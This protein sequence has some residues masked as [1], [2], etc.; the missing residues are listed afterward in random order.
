MRI[1]DTKALK[2]IICRFVVIAVLS[3]A[4]VGVENG[5]S[6]MSVN[7]EVQ[8][9]VGA[10]TV[11][12]SI[13]AGN[14]F[15][16]FEKIRVNPAYK[17]LEIEPGN[18]KNFTVTVENKDNKTIELKPKPVIIPYTENFINE[19]WISINPSEKS[20]NPGEK[21]EF[22]VNVDI[23][24]DADLGNYA[25]LLAFAE[26]VPEGDVAGSYPNFPRTMQLNI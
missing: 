16:E 3:I 10:S 12:S 17:Y 13:P 1:L 25:V 18:S 20:L 7:G 26:K 9:K 2:E 8:P 4:C 11:S 24:K 15:P 5:N 19:S 22:Q 6:A 23:P 21:Q 14:Y